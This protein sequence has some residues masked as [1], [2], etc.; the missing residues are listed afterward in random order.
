MEEWASLRVRFVTWYQLKKKKKKKKKRKRW[1]FLV[2]LVF[3]RKGYTAET[4]PGLS[5]P[6]LL[7]EGGRYCLGPLFGATAKNFL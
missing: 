2:F 3:K 5:F 7:F 1:R 6:G 4:L